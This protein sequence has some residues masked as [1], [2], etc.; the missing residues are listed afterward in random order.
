MKCYICGYDNVN[1]T[2]STCPNCASELSLLHNIDALALKFKRLKIIYV[3]SLLLLVISI[4]TILFVLCS[5]RDEKNK[6]AAILKELEA[7]NLMLKQKC[8]EL[9]LRLL[10]APE[11]SVGKDTAVNAATDKLA[12]D[13]IEYIVQ[14]DDN[15]WVIAQKF[16]GDGHK[17]RK[18]ANDNKIK[19]P[20]AILVGQ[21]VMII[22]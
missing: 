16:F 22:K 21:K 6:D 20:Y 5:S 2:M 12:G 4:V 15:L 3:L 11:K 10:N 17:F 19:R 18:L 1:Q 9:T 7:D 8:D 14:K 13:T